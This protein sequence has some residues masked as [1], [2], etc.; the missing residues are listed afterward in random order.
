[1]TIAAQLASS[2]PDLG[3][4]S[5]FVS[6]LKVTNGAT[7]TTQIAVTADAVVLRD[8]SNAMRGFG[9]VSVTASSGSVGANA[10]DAGTVAN[11]TWYAVWLIGKEDGAI[12]ALL[13]LS[14]TA[15]TMPSGYTYKHRVGWART[16]GS[17]QFMRFIQRGK[18][19][20]YW[21]VAGSTTTTL[22]LVVNAA[23]GN[24]ATPTWVS[25]SLAAVVPPTAVAVTMLLRATT[26]GGS[27]Q[28]NILVAPNAAYGTGA[29]GSNPPPG[30]AS[31]TDTGSV[32]ISPHFVQAEIQLETAQTVYYA[33][34][35]TCFANVLGWED[36]F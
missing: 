21:V 17:A 15:P 7:P 8:T 35:A 9:V 10:L 29:S 22:P 2:A 30:A 28:R 36:D 5:G 23:A 4:L 25:L 26:A 24:T 11:N 32:G 31:A 18:K 27:G 14:S 20:R 6:A 12:A 19:A 1:M 34:E 3:R 16:N 13:S 33:C